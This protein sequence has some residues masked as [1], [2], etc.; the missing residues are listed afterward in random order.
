MNA[1][2]KFLIVASMALAPA[3]LSLGGSVAVAAVNATTINSP[4]Q[5]T[6][7]IQ[8]LLC[9]FVSWFIWVV[10]L[11]S[12]IM[13]VYAAFEYA[14]A[15]DDTEKVATGRKTITYAAVGVVVALC[16]AGLPYVVESLF[17]SST[18]IPGISCLGAN[19]N[20]GSLNGNLN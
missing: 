8:N 10:I 6:T 11:V 4:V 13:I 5:N 7:D 1:L 18:N 19:P 14:T 20:G 2:K 9:N 17:G 16:A 12:V 3:S 15:G